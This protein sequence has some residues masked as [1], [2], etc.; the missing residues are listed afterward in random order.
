MPL[1]LPNLDNLIYE[2]LVS[3]LTADIPKNTTEWTDFNP[4][5][6]G[7]TIMELLAFISESLSY[8][9]DLLPDELYLNFLKLLAGVGAFKEATDPA[10]RKLLDFIA[11]ANE[12]KAGLLSMQAQA[13][14]FLNS[15]YRAVTG[16]DFKELII[17]AF[18]E[19]KRV[20]VVAAENEVKNI[21]I[22]DPAMYGSF[23]ELT[24]SAVKELAGRVRDFLEP[25]RLIGTFIAVQTAAYLPVCLKISLACTNPAATIP[26]NLID[27]VSAKVFYYLDSLTGGPDGSGWPYGRKL[28]VYELF[29]IVEQVEGVTHVTE[30]LTQDKQGQWVQFKELLVPGLIYLQNV[31]IQIEVE[32]ER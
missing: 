32:I 16:T 4:A 12:T 29:H 14:H 27:W 17:E 11:G 20:E 9:A 28:I 6:P 24:G 1:Q 8:R 22:P 3:E 23:A 19:I 5:D 7:I 31:E 15:K 21:I 13:Q 26:Q 2:D 18:P 10:H 30:I 25:R